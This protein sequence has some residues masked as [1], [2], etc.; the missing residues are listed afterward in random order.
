MEKATGIHLANAT[1]ATSKASVS[2]DQER[3]GA[4][5]S[6]VD[7]STDKLGRALPLRDLPSL[8]LNATANVTKWA[9]GLVSKDEVP[10]WRSGRSAANDTLDGAGNDTATSIRLSVSNESLLA[11]SSHADRR[12]V[13]A[14]V[15]D[16]VDSDEDEELPVKP[17]TAVTNSSVRIDADDDVSSAGLSSGNDSLSSNSSH[18]DKRAVVVVVVRREAE[19]DSA[20]FEVDESDS[21]NSSAVNRTRREPYY[22]RP[23]QVIDVFWFA[24]IKRC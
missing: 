21:V 19:N 8:I 22:R 23:Y 20:D 3:R 17:G 15:E 14:L 9:K 10:E 1:T 18:A 11:N 24:M 12:D 2:L 13:E 16:E 7:N 6:S 5:V 4:N